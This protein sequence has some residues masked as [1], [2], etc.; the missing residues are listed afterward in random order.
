[1]PSIQMHYEFKVR[2]AKHP[3]TQPGSTIILTFITA[4]ANMAVPPLCTGRTSCFL[5]HC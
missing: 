3:H 2:S 4:Q 5:G 1:M